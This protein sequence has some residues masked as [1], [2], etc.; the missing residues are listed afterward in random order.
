MDVINT[1]LNDHAFL[2]Q[3]SQ[4]AYQPAS[5]G[6]RRFKDEFGLNARTV[7]SSDVFAYILEEQAIVFRGSESP[8]SISGFI[9][10]IRDLDAIPTLEGFHRGFIRGARDILPLLS[11]S[12]RIFTG[13]SLGGAL[14]VMTWLAFKGLLPDAPVP[15]SPGLPPPSEP[16]TCVTFGCPRL[17]IETLQ[18]VTAYVHA[19]DPV[20]NLPPLYAFVGRRIQI[21]TVPDSHRVHPEWAVE[22]HFIQHYINWVPKPP[23]DDDLHADVVT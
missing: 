9:D 13:H 7:S 12:L 20:P 2:A 4:I 6:L 21:G 19:D 18:E 23:G 1:K 10:W 8:L 14:A 17:Y 5:L 16:L 22:S 3:A 15:T 11:P